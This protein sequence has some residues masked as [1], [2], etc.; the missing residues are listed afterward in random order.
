MPIF[1]LGARSPKSCERV[2][3]LGGRGSLPGLG[4]SLGEN[5]GFSLLWEGILMLEKDRRKG[6]RSSRRRRIPIP[7]G[8]F[9]EA[10]NRSLGMGEGEGRRSLMVKNW[11]R[12]SGKDIGTASGGKE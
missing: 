3:V 4:R 12:A 5:M 10:Y 7:R 1:F 11:T 2:F 9:Q 6:D 8:K